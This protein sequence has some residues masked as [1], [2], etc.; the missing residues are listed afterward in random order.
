V[1]PGDRFRVYMACASRSKMRAHKALSDSPVWRAWRRSRSAASSSMRAVT[2][3]RG[4]YTGYGP[5]WLRGGLGTTVPSIA[6]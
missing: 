2:W 3:Y 4:P 1:E 5:R 6:S